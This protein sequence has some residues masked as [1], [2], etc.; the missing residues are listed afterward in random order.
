MLS[1]ST[2][3]ESR[4]EKDLIKKMTSVPFKFPERLELSVHLKNILKKLCAIETSERMS[5]EDFS[6]LKFAGG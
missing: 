4:T 6:K 2:P 1:G 3:W 5:A